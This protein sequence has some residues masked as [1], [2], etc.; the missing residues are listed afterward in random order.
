MSH[1][2]NGLRKQVSEEKEGPL[3]FRRKRK[4]KCTR[5]KGVGKGMAVLH[6]EHILCIL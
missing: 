4:G 6:R 5:R 1:R 2:R 3:E